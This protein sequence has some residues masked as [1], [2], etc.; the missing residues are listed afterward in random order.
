MNE[1]KPSK[2]KNVIEKAVDWLFKAEGPS[3]AQRRRAKWIEADGVPS[4][5]H[6]LRART[7]KS[8][9]RLVDQQMKKKRK[10]AQ[11]SRRVNRR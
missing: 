11:H 10:I 7:G 9:G 8:G 3:R 1:R 4:R 6:G 2:E 5:K